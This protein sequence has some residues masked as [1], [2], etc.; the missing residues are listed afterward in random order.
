MRDDYEVTVVWCA[1]CGHR[2]RT[3]ADERDDHPCPR[4]GAWPGEEEWDSEDEQDD[5]TR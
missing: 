4:C 1:T 3:L 2:Y 5:D